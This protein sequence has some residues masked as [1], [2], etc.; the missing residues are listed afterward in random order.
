MREGEVTL[1]RAAEA[2]ALAEQ[3]L[4]VL[5]ETGKIVGARFSG[6][7]WLVPRTLLDRLRGDAP[8]SAHTHLGRV[9]VR[10]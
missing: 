4:R 9:D 8:H 7:R 1:E 5:C 6:G 3:P 10:P 2:G